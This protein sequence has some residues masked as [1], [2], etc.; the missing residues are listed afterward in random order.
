MK[1]SKGKSLIGLIL[2]LVIIA[3]CGFV[4]WKGVVRA[5]REVPKILSSAWIWPAVS[6]LLTKL[7]RKIL[8]RKI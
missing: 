1:N 6:V 2:I 4:S 7:P 3:A 8:R 5:V